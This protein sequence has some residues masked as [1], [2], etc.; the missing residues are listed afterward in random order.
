MPKANS[1]YKEIPLNRGLTA[2]VDDA[3]YEILSR[4]R[5]CVP[6]AGKRPYALRTVGDTGRRLAMHRVILNAPD[7]LQVDH[8]NGDGLDNRR[9]NLR[10]ATNAQNLQ[11]Q[12]RRSTNTSGYKGVSLYRD[13]RWSARIRA[14]GRRVFL[15]YFATPE[16]AHAAYCAAAEKYHG[17]F[18]RTA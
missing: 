8:I 15:G 6:P 2:I 18:A 4:H 1:V 12:K 16:L 7:G 11:N 13:G 10:L 5:W 9:S 14:N 17:E 3:D